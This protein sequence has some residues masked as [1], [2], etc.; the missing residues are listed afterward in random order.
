MVFLILVVAL[1]TGGCAKPSV[2]ESTQ[3]VTVLPSTAPVP[4]VGLSDDEIDAFRLLMGYQAI[5]DPVYSASTSLF[6]VSPVTVRSASVLGTS[7]VVSANRR[8][9]GKV[10][11][12]GV[13]NV[14]A[15]RWLDVINNTEWVENTTGV[16]QLRRVMM[17]QGNADQFVYTIGWSYLLPPLMSVSG[18]MTEDHVMINQVTDIVTRHGIQTIQIIKGD[19]IKGV[20][21]TMTVAG[22][23]LS[24]S[25]ASTCPNRLFSGV[26]PYQLTLETP[27]GSR[28][29]AGTLALEGCGMTSTLSDSKGRTLAKLMLSPS[30][31]YTAQVYQVSTNQ[32]I[33]L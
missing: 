30:L 20:T 23:E 16:Y 3:S 25:D 17:M 21:M 12:G 14:D 13:S 22:G 10:A 6:M 9:L 8:D 29:L 11:F 1:V 18:V 28:T 7:F 31:Q 4:F 26:L 32:L 19:G 2:T 33:D 24:Y 15:R 5:P 27:S